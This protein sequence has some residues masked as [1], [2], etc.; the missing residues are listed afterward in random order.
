MTQPV[1]ANEDRRWFLGAAGKTLAAAFGIAAL[2]SA[3]PASASNGEGQTPVRGESDQGDTTLLVTYQCCVDCFN[4]P[5]CSQ[6]GQNTRYRCRP[7]SGSCSAFCTGCRS[8]IGS[9]YTITSGC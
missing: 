6:C 7:N 9:C 1:H 8:Y 2:G 3:T 4:C 5:N